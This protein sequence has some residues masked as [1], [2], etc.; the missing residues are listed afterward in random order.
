VPGLLEAILA[1]T[2]PIIPSTV[3]G[4]RKSSETTST[5]LK[6]HDRLSRPGVSPTTAFIH[7]LPNVKAAPS[8]NKGPN[9][10]RGSTRSTRRPP[11]TLPRQ[12]PPSMIPMT[13]V[14]TTSEAP[15]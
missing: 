10:L 1:T 5:V 3:A 9:A 8:A 12:I 4:T 14:Q 15:T 11:S 6:F 2:G 13:L 7:R